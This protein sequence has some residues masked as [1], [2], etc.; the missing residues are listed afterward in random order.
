M[1]KG[2]HHL[3]DAVTRVWFS[4]GEVVIRQYLAIRRVQQ[5][6]NQKWLD[7]ADNLIKKI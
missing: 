6:R 5:N 1:R 3:V 7:L 2:S 4:N